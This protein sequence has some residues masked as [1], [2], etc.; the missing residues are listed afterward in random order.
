MAFLLTQ[1]E[2]VAQGIRRLAAEQLDL[3][4]RQLRS[5]TGDQ[6]VHV[7]ETRKCMKRLRAVALLG[8]AEL[9]GE[10]FRLENACYR[11]A[12]LQLAGA[13]DAAALLEALE[14]L[15]AAAGSRVRRGRF[16]T[17]GDWLGERRDAMHAS[18]QG[19]GV[20][21]Q[22]VLNDLRWARKRVSEWPLDGATWKTVEAGVRRVYQRGRTG[23]ERTAAQTD[24][25]VF[26]EW[27]K[28]AK[29]QWY[30][31]Q[32]LREVWPGMMAPLADQLG[33]LGELLGQDHDLAVLRHTVLQEMT[34]P[35]R[36]STL[37]ALL[38]LVD[39]RQQDLRARA[40]QLGHRLYVER[41]NVF[42][43]RLRGY[44]RAWRPE[45]ADPEPV[46]AAPAAAGVLA[47]KVA[48]ECA[49]D[50]GEGPLWNPLEKRLYWVDIP[51][52][53]L[54]R[55]DPA[56]ATHEECLRAPRAIGGF[57]VQGDG[58]LLL[59]MAGGAVAAWRGGRLE[60]L[61][62]GLEAERDTRFN[63]VIADPAGRVFCGTMPG[64][65]GN[66]RLYRLGPDGTFAVVLADV[67]LAN[68]MGFSPDRRTFYFTDSGRSVIQQFDYDESTGA[69]TRPR[70]LVDT[71]AEPGV[72]DGMTVDAEG[73]IWSARWGGGC[74][75]RYSP[76]G[77]QLQR[78]ELP[79]PKVSSVAF[80]GQGHRDLYVTT[81]GGQDRAAEGEKAG[82]LFRVRVGVRGLPEYLSRIGP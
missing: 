56:R 42:A 33:E 15:V 39:R 63:D 48:A 54:Y 75:I 6:D 71:S 59:F 49:C 74:V 47:P 31:T 81:A 50:T 73:C 3:A 70:T 8:R 32:M 46:R 52:G 53:R 40:R 57:T 4:L 66:A 77:Q 36:A 51:A 20:S 14:A 78:I 11:D 19:A 2:P 65:G 26:H 45:A 82:C 44:W 58:S 12:A 61:T 69:I 18:A 21:R 34:R 79:V 76:A 68:G 62:E 60:Y 17:V 28:W 1:D 7:H 16:A 27:R 30:H 22:Q 67:G 5:R 10:V 9:G 25:A 24:D 37:Q 80:G 41:P 43:D 55:F 72:P 64:P 38:E 35:I 23:F 29:Y 13:R